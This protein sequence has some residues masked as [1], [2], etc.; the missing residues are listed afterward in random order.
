M[1]SNDLKRLK[2]EEKKILDYYVNFCEKNNLKYYLAYGTLLGAIRHN[3]F[4]PWDDD[5]DVHM[6]PQDYQKF[7]NLF[8][9]DNNNDYFLQTIDTEKY[10]HATFTKI[11]KNNSCMVEKEWSYMKIHKGINIDIFPLY[12]YPD[13]SKERKKFRFLLKLSTLLVSKNIK[14]NSVKN[15][16]IFGILRIIPRNVTN[17]I[18]NKIVYKLLNYDGNYSK[19]ITESCEEGYNKEWF[20][21]VIPVKFEGTYYNAPKKY[22]AVLTKMYGDYMT[23]P[24][25]EDRVGHGNGEIYLS[26][27]K[28]YE[29]M[30]K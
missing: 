3:G 9:K 28:N 11:R 8:K 18:S 1:K 23:P 30:E 4:I 27:D 19:Y 15:K 22:D 21:E 26:F 10:F 7:I 6:P 24:K 25:K 5:I 17:N 20:N 14:T 29:D 16:I 2:I 12:P 13:D